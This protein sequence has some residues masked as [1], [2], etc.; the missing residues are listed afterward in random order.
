MKQ[1]LFYIVWTFVSSLLLKSGIELIFDKNIGNLGPIL[2]NVFL[3]ISIIFP[4]V[5]VFNSSTKQ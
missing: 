4:I 5:S 2:I 3:Q 1:L